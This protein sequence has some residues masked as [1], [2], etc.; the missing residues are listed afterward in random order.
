MKLDFDIYIY[1][2]VLSL[3]DKHIWCQRHFYGSLSKEFCLSLI[4]PISLSKG[5]S[6]SEVAQSRNCNTLQR[7]HEKRQIPKLRSN[8]TDKSR[9]ETE[10]Y[11]F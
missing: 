5:V 2:N 6:S 11:I 8:F 4:S 1:L 10:F 7:K 3:L 9:A